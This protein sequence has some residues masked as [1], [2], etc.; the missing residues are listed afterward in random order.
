LAGE[1]WKLKKWFSTFM[2]ERTSWNSVFEESFGRR[3]AL[4]DKNSEKAWKLL[5]V[6]KG[7]CKKSCWFYKTVT[8]KL[9]CLMYEDVQNAECFHILNKHSLKWI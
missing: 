3:V 4:L 2:I 9:C 8:L 6:S 5:H 7:S 1:M